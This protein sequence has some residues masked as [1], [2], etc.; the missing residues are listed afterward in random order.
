MVELDLIQLA[1]DGVIDCA[2]PFSARVT[3]HTVTLDDV[4]VLYAMCA[5]DALGIPVMLHR[6]GVIQTTD[7]ESGASIRIQVDAS[8]K[9]TAEPR[10]AVV[11]CSVSAGPGPLSSLC[12]PLV[13][14]F[15]ARATAERFLLSRPELTGTILSLPD[16]AAC[17]AT[18]FGGVLH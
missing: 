4:T 1:D 15:E 14:A 2:Y 18:V 16:A 6:A 5:V 10:G 13:N 17:G 3:T 7:P 12:C 11:L 8:G 9:A